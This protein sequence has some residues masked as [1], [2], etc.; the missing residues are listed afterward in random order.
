M[1]RE[2]KVIITAVICIAVIEVVAVLKGVDGVLLAGALTIIGG[3]AGYGLKAAKKPPE[4][5]N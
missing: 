3:L 5:S 2:P 4:E 1:Q